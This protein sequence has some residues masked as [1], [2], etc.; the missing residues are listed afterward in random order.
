M[1]Q[2]VVRR[3][4][5]EALLDLG[6]RRRQRHRQ[7]HQ[8]HQHLRHMHPAR[9]QSLVSSLSL[10]LTLLSYNHRPTCLTRASG[11]KQT[12]APS[13]PRR[14]PFAS[15]PSR[16]RTSPNQT[17]TQT[18][19]DIHIPSHKRTHTYTHTDR[20]TDGDRCRTATSDEHD[21][22]AAPRRRHLQHHGAVVARVAVLLRRGD[23][24]MGTTRSSRRCSAASRTPIS[25]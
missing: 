8:H 10:S 13:T 2:Q 1:E 16:A 11:G 7:H 9:R 20:D 19:R 24:I 21:G 23:Q 5:V 12:N 25:I 4:Q 17:H 3:L 14:A 22:A 15:A 18:Q 6:V